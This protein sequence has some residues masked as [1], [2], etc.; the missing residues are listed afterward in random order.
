ML[1]FT[2]AT[3]ITEAVKGLASLIPKAAMAGVT[4]LDRGAGNR[5]FISGNPVT[6]HTGSS[7]IDMSPQQIVQ[8]GGSCTGTAVLLAAVLRS[9]GIP[10]RV[11]GCSTELP[12]NDNDHQ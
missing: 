12:D 3:T 1:Q 6:W 7:P 5:E 10:A 8:N 4:A 9:V 2:S 11:T